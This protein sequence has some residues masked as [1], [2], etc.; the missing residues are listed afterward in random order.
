M[1]G[2]HDPNPSI[3]DSLAALLDRAQVPLPGRTLRAMAA[4]V[5]GQSIDAGRLTRI[6]AFERERFVRNSNPPR[7]CVAIDEHGVELRP[8]VWARGQWRLARRIATDDVRVAWDAQAALLA[9][10]LRKQLRRD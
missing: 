10:E 9:L 7:L 1:Q 8:R 4:A 3:A 5:R 6:A 2:T